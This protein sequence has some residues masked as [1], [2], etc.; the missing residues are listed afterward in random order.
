MNIPNFKFAS[1]S[2]VKSIEFSAPNMPK[3]I[4]G[5]VDNG[6]ISVEI[7]SAKHKHEGMPLYSVDLEANLD[8][9]TVDGIQVFTLKIVYSRLI[10]ILD[11]VSEEDCENIFQ[12]IVP[13]SMYDDLRIKVRQTIVDAGLPPFMLQEFNRGMIGFEPEADRLGYNWMV[14]AISDDELINRF[15]DVL[16]RYMSMG[17]IAYEQTPLYRCFYRFLVPVK[18]NHPNY[19]ECDSS[20]WVLI[21]H[22]I[23]AEGENVSIYANDSGELELEFD[24]LGKERRTLSSLSL[25][26]LKALTKD[27]GEL[28]FGLTF[29]SI[30]SI[31]N[32]ANLD[33]FDRL[34]ANKPILREE[35]HAAYGTNAPDA[36]PEDVE[37]VDSVYERIQKCE[38]QTMFYR[39]S[40][41]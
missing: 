41:E 32:I 13:Y 29:A 37:F 26:E 14:K 1:D 21:F 27:L 16:K 7:K 2:M 35:L 31:I 8:S 10:E 39:L 5:D 33:S 6:N 28:S 20:F 25:D 30:V 19:A 24:F 40:Q 3:I 23:Y 15:Y 17:H 18:Y 4:Y 12:V 36:D 38:L 9:V 22:L 34:D 11:D